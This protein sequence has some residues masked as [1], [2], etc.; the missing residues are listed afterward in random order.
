M[1]ETATN[2]DERLA[3]VEKDVE[4]LQTAR[5]EDKQAREEASRKIELALEVLR[6]EVQ[7]LQVR[8]AYFFGGIAVISWLLEVFLRK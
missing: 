3:R 8:M 1:S 5:A 7:K 4:H 2:M 6:N